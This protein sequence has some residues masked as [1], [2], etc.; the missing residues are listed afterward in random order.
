MPVPYVSYYIHV[1]KGRFRSQALLDER[2]LL[3]CMAY[4]DLNPI[5]AGMATSPEESDFTSI[6]ER[7]RAWSE[8]DR[9]ETSL[10]ESAADP[11]LLPFQ[12]AHE[13]DEDVGPIIPF[14]MAHYLELV[15]HSGRVIRLDKRGYIP[16]ELPPILTRLGV[17]QD[18]Y[19]KY[20]G[21]DD[22]RLVHGA[23]A[24]IQKFA[25]ALKKKFFKNYRELGGLYRASG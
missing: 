7:I 19:V 11:W 20:I 9:I 22:K 4:V 17:N 6:Q 16:P 13:E 1:N 8:F 15:E 23:A 10:K 5:R 21:N 3:T 25:K 12:R 14:Q 24:A 18:E 2:A